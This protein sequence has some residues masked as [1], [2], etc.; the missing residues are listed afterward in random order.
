LILALASSRDPPRLQGVDLSGLDLS[1]LDLRGANLMGA[2]LAG[3]T[4]RQTELGEWLPIERWVPYAIGESA[5]MDEAKFPRVRAVL[6]EANLAGA[7]LTGA[8]LERAFLRDANLR[9]AK[10]TGARLRE[11][12]L[13]G[14]N[15]ANAILDDA[16][17]TGA[18]MQ[19]VVL[20]D[21]IGVSDKFTAALRFH[22][23]TEPARLFTSQAAA[24][25]W[26]ERADVNPNP[27]ALKQAAAT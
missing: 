23:R 26:D 4:L 7:D 11:A 17:L 20:T 27:P 14:A 24:D 9:G 21:A 6:T 2:S 15:L 13:Y 19:G 12:T 10:L 18:D 16:D 22:S 3:A 5:S 1:W 25:Q 8:N